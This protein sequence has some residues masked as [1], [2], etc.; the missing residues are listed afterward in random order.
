MDVARQVE[1]CSQSIQKIQK[2]P[3]LGKTRQAMHIGM[4][5]LSIEII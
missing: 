1:I 2:W 5:P 3:F 4:Q